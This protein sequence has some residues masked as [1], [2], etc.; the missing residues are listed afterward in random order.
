MRRVESLIKMIRQ[1]CASVNYGTD[2]SGNPTSGITDELILEYLNDGQGLLQSRIIEAYPQEFLVTKEI[3]VDGSAEYSIDDHVLFNNK[4]ILVEYS[5]TG[6]AKDYYPLD[7]I[8]LRDLDYGSGRD[9]EEYARRS[10]KIIPSPIATNTAAKLRVTYY[11]ALDTLD[12]RRGVVDVTPAQ[13]AEVTDITCNDIAGSPEDFRITVGVGSNS[14]P[15]GG[16]ITFSSPTRDFYVWV[17]RAG[18]GTDPAL[19]GKV[20]IEWPVSAGLSAGQTKT[21]IQNLIDDLDDFTAVTFS[22][23]ACTVTGVLDGNTTNPLNVSMGAGITINNNTNGTG[24][25]FLADVI[26]DGNGGYFTINTPTISYYVWIDVGGDG[27][28]PA[29]AGLTGIAVVL[30]YWDTAT[31]AA[32]AI[33]AAIDS[34]AGFGAASA[35]N[36]VTVTNADTGPATD[37]TDGTLTTAITVNVTTQGT[38][39]VEIAL[40]NDATLDATGIFAREDYVCA[41]DSLG[42]VQEYSIQISSYSA[43]TIT[44]PAQ[45]TTAIAAGDYIVVG[46]YAT[47][48]SALPDECERFI[49]TYAQ[50]RIFQTLNSKKAGDEGGNV[51]MMLKDIIDSYTETDHDIKHIPIIDDD[52][53]T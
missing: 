33:A 37:A 32:T 45:L 17:N 5:S 12:I 36:V 35:S 20:S 1:H 50:M 18:G 31:V 19:A 26:A 29:P 4:L 21:S 40:T 14:L 51:E 2:T 34:I 43:P 41:V 25:A 39:I 27:V 49:K 6:N 15:Q 3:S 53:F 48:H 38:D 16:Y 22:S 7:Q 52:L 30:N 10:G 24:N 44:I 47:T 28:D 11:R 42:N 9:I 8:T 13:I 46:K 23:T